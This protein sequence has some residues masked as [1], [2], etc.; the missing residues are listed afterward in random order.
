MLSSLFMLFGYLLGMAGSSIIL[1]TPVSRVMGFGEDPDHADPESSADALL[2][3]FAV[4]VGVSALWFVTVP[5]YY[6]TRRKLIPV[7]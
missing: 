7:D 6:A 4:V 2:V 5:L 1:Y 3:L